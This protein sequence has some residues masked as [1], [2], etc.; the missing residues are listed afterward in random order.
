MKSS[1]ESL[2][3]EWKVNAFPASSPTFQTFG[4]LILWFGWYGFNCGSTLGISGAYSQI[5]A[6]VAVTTTLG[7]AGGSLCATVLTYF[8]DTKTFDLGA[9]GNG[10]L[11]GLVSITAPC[12]VVEPFG[13]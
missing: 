13:R 12:P 7:A 4:V 5:A 2:P 3:F 10:V 11:A 8:L 6:K 9:I 1:A